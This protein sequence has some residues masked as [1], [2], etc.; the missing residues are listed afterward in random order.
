LQIDPRMLQKGA[1]G[2]G[3]IVTG[4]V[5]EHG[6]RRGPGIGGLDLF[7]QR[8]GGLGIDRVVVA[9]HGGHR[10][11]VDR[12]VDVQAPPPGVALDGKAPAALDP[13]ASE[14]R[15]VLRVGG[16]HEQEH[17]VLA[18]VFLERFVRCDEVF[19]NLR[20]GRLARQQLRL[21]VAV[22]EPMQQR[23]HAAVGVVHAKAVFDPAHDRGRARMQLLP[24]V[25]IELG[26]LRGCEQRLATDVVHALQRCN[27]ALLV[28]LEVV[29]HRIVVDQKCGSD[30]ARAPTAA[31]QDHGIDPVGL[32]GVACRAVGAAQFR[33]FLLVQVV[34]THAPKTK[35]SHM[36]APDSC[37]E[38]SDE[39]GINK[40]VITS[41][42]T[43]QFGIVRR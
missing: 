16:V 15:I 37:D 7:E 31:E 21:F 18:F 24:E 26:Q 12:A 29:A 28:A 33:E 32:A 19:L 9:D 2:F 39:T 6:D 8:D 38:I 1:H 34:V 13:A 36:L 14:D 20:S 43:H 10:L 40:Q 35:R 42:Q 30:L 22:S 5:A 41:Q 23:G 27:T 3:A 25:R 11:D 4:V 17:I